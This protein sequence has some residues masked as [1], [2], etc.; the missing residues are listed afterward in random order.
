MGKILRKLSALGPQP[1]RARV[2]RDGTKRRMSKEK[3]DRYEEFIR[4]AHGKILE[5]VDEGAKTFNKEPGEVRNRIFTK[6]RI[7]ATGDLLWQAYVHVRAKEINAGKPK[8]ERLKASKVA[9]LLAS[10]LGEYKN[11]PKEEQAQWLQALKEHQADCDVQKRRNRK[12]EEVDHAHT[13]N[14]IAREMGNAEMRYGLKSFFMAVRSD[15]QQRINPVILCS[16]EVKEFIS[17]FLGKT[18]EQMARDFECWSINGEEGLLGRAD[19]KN[20][21][22]LK[23]ETRHSIQM[24]LNIAANALL[25]MDTPIEMNYTSYDRVIVGRYGL[26]LV[27]WPC[28]D[29]VCNPG[30]LTTKGELLKLHAAL[31][32]KTCRWEKVP[33]EELA[34]LTAEMPPPKERSDKNKKRGSYKKRSKETGGGK[35]TDIADAAKA[36]GKKAGAAKKAAAS[37]AAAAAA[38]T[39]APPTPT[40]ATSATT[41]TTASTAPTPAPPAPTAAT[42]V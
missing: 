8:G 10:E 20:T 5:L 11:R 25:G 16:D 35:E 17:L 22:Q 12:G 2:K 7:S 9:T 1:K 23:S 19:R 18:P 26:R 33:E 38:R 42:T 32:N 36:R 34:A 24:R 6:T 30:N 3:K 28:G 14:G 27:G 31:T 4:N 13:I 15:V 29:C 21:N 39:A 37:K 41:T 40:P